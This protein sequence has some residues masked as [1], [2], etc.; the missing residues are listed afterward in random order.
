MS[1]LRFIFVFYIYIF[2]YICVNVFSVYVFF[3]STVLHCA[4][5]CQNYIFQSFH[6]IAY[7]EEGNGMNE[8]CDTCSS[9]TFYI[10]NLFRLVFSYMSC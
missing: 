10:Y 5:L 1:Q 2:I 4:N 7:R 8:K 3:E 9:V 6:N